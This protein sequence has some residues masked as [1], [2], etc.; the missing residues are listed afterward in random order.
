MLI[1][2]CALLEACAITPGRATSFRYSVDSPSATCRNSL[3][4]CV[5]LY[6]KE[7]ASATAVVKA[8]LDVATRT[9]LEQALTEC[10]DQARSEVILRH[11]GDFRALIPNADECNQLAKNAKTSSSRA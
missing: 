9:S 7:M 2:L 3:S 11:E 4:G 5:A 6:G 8:A 1:A 10:A